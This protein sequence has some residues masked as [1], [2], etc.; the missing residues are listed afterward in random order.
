MLIK[1][2]T[3]DHRPAHVH[4]FTPSGEVIIFIPKRGKAVLREAQP[5]VTRSD[6]GKA[7]DI[8]NAN[9][10]ACRSTWRKYHGE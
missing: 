4:A 5:G 8:V 9:I 1:V 7:L 2:N 10:D 6:V 3:H